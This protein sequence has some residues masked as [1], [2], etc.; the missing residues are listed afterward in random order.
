MP[1]G[2][3]SKRRLVG[4]DY[5]A[6]VETPTTSLDLSI[7]PD[8]LWIRAVRPLSRREDGVSAETNPMAASKVVLCVV[9]NNC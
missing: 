7:Y 8:Y 1:S 3:R 6:N 2:V 9:E 4:V 5:M